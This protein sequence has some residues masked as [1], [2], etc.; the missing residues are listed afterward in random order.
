[1]KFK[2][3]VALGTLALAASVHAQTINYFFT[4]DGLQEVPPNASPASGTGNVSINTLTNELSWTIS[5]V[6]LVAPVT[7]AHFHGAALPGANAG[8]QVNIGSI[9]GL[10]S[11]MVGNTTITN[12]QKTDLLNGLW[13]VNI[14]TSQFPGGEIRGQVVPTPGAVALLGVA[15]SLFVLPRRRH[16]QSL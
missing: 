2:A 7:G 4:L 6:D 15:G 10:F 14:H 13:Y 9:S 3:L 8:V 1:M 5:F 11:P 12:A 16:A